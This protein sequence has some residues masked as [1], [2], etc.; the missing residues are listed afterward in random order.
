M[1][2]DTREGDDAL[3]V[4]ARRAL[5]RERRRTAD[6][7]DAFDDLHRRVREIEPVTTPRSGGS[8]AATGGAVSTGAATR[9]LTGVAG[10][11]PGTD[12]LDVVREAYEETVM[13]VPH[14]EGEYGESYA[15]TLAAE[16]SPDL[17]AALVTGDRFDPV[18]KRTLLDAVEEGRS[19]RE[20]LLDALDAEAESLATYRERVASLRTDLDAVTVRGRPVVAFAD[21]GTAAVDDDADAADLSVVAPFDA[22]ADVRSELLG[23][24][25]RCDAVAADR[26][27]TVHEQA[28]RL[29]L[30][31]ETADVQR[32]CYGSLPVAYPVLSAVTD[33]S[34]RVERCRRTVERA[35]ASCC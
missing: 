24:G 6:E 32:Y 19:R 33:L 20:R 15:E 16:F 31:V 10:N 28:R 35:M 22:L 18:C 34:G 1:P 27:A 3:L 17:A 30:P 12:R 26:Q 25:E 11:D 29:S 21:P 13:S 4:R 2:A 14:F 23:L 7:R 5:D 8:D 9:T